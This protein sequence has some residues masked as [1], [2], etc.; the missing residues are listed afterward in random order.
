MPI[1]E[2]AGKLGETLLGA[3]F[4]VAGKEHDVFAFAWAGAALIDNPI[5][6]MAGSLRG[7]DEGGKDERVH[8]DRL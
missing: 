5:P 3:V 1:G 8:W 2:D 4:L 7:K 6:G